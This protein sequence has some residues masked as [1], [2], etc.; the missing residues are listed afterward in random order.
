MG[1]P[2]RTT[3]QINA[4]KNQREHRRKDRRSETTTLDIAVTVFRENF[5]SWC[6]KAFQNETSA[7]TRVSGK[8][9]RHQLLRMERKRGQQGSS[10]VRH[11]LSWSLSV[12]PALK[13]LGS[14]HGS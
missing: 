10:G 4:E 13:F 5:T 7:Q 3:I 1:M 9:F 14:Y 12:K 6:P 2:N 11:D 8:S